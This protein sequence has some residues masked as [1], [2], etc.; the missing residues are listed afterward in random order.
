MVQ[1]KREEE[2]AGTLKAACLKS[3][4]V[5][6]IC[7]VIQRIGGALPHT[8]TIASVTNRNLRKACPSGVSTSL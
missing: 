2:R 5:A 4:L 3:E 1:D 8:S 6:M 7:S